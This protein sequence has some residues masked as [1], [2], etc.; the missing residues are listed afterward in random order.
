MFDVH[1]RMEKNSSMHYD[2]RKLDCL[3]T[4]FKMVRKFDYAILSQCLVKQS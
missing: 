2:K 1:L 3:K 4:Y